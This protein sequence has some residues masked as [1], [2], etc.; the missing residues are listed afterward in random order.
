MT[1][2]LIHQTDRLI[3]AI[4]AEVEG[5]VV[6]RASGVEATVVRAVAAALLT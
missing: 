3:R 5:V 4:V 1:A 2:F 6:E